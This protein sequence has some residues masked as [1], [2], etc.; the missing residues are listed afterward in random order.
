MRTCL[1]L[2]LSFLLLLSSSV[3]AYEVKCY[4]SGILFFQ[5]YAKK[6]DVKYGLVI[7]HHKNYSDFLMADCVIRH[8]HKKAR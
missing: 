6:V 1:S 5:G 8:N 4:S 2:C 3:F 7:L